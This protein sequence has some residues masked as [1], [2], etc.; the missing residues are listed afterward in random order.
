MI[1]VF[2]VNPGGAEK[3]IKEKMNEAME[4]YGKDGHEGVTIAW[5]A[6][7]N[8]FRCCGVSNS[9]DWRRSNKNIPDSCYKG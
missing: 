5:N 3:E 1:Y 7:Q 9:T 6:A 8:T 4:N 2:V